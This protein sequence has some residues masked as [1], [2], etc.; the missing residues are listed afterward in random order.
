MKTARP[1][2][3]HLPGQWGGWDHDVLAAG[4]FL[5]A[6]GWPTAVPAALTAVE[7]LILTDQPAA[8]VSLPAATG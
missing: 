8:A 7:T 2:T 3:G 5:D 4:G 1:W 6:D